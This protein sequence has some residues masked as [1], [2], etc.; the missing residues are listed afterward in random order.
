MI[1]DEMRLHL[2][3]KLLPFW[4]KLKDEENG[5]FYGLITS[6]LV[7]HKD[8]EKGCILNNRIL[9]FFSNAYL[10]LKDETLKAYADQAYLF[11]RDKCL[12]KDRGG[13]YW[14]ITYDGK[15]LDTMKHTYNQA[16]AVYALSSYYRAF[17][18]Q[19]AIKI[20][21]GLVDTIETKCF[22]EGGYLEAL[23]INFAPALNDKTSENGIIAER[24]MNTLLHVMEAYTEYFL[25]TGDQKV[26]K[27]LEWI[28]DLFAEKLYNPKLH[29]MEVFFD[30]DMNSL[31][32]LHSFGHDIETAWLM[33]RTLNILKNQEYVEKMTPIIRDLE[34]QIYNEAYSHHSLANE[35]ENGKV[36]ES[37]IWW[38]QAESI[39][40][41][42]NA[43]QK[44]GE[45]K[46]LKAAEDIWEFTK[47]KVVDSREGSE[48]FWRIDVDG[49]PDMGEAMVDPWKCPYHNGRMCME[50]MT[51]AN[52]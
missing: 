33:E 49:N 31:I 17:G 48:W 39:V 10:V 47:S 23:D 46:Y 32:D 27:K 52:A 6:D 43:Y 13:V 36:D 8:G 37:R 41:F 12:D 51:R 11:L 26:G 18:N 28:L 35:S 22:D 3:Q 44:T 9:W 4:E 2:T 1:K 7:L 45:M 24:T 15:P 5:G 16:F 40:G 38:V 34:N 29:R 20:A 25:A 14:A 19:E 21:A 50:I 42:Y 30:R